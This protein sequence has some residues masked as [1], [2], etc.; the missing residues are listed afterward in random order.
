M[1][2]IKFRAWERKTKRMVFK[3]AGYSSTREE[4]SIDQV[5]E[6]EYGEDPFFAVQF[7]VVYKEVFEGKET[8][9]VEYI[10][11]DQIFH[12]DRF[13]PMEFTGL[14]DSKGKEIYEGDIL[15]VRELHDGDEY[16]WKQPTGP[17]IP[18][19]VKW[20]DN[21]KQ[22]DF[23]GCSRVI[24]SPSHFEVIGNIYENPNLLSQDK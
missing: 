5:G 8:M 3:V 24:Y 9:V 16:A 2:E 4:I 11:Y 14:K 22:F 7:E 1:R 12:N 18:C 23:G 10:L 19:E 13:V 6:S 21:Y 17:A 20:D 15:V